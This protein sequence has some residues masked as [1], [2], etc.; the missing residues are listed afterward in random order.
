MKTI[1]TFDIQIYI[2]IDIDKLTS[3][4]SGSNLNL[5]NPRFDCYTGRVRLSGLESNGL[6]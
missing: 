5:R 2:C 3:T 1:I 4:L 6:D